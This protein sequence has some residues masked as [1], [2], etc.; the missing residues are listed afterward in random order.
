MDKTGRCLN[1][2]E[3]ISPNRLTKYEKARLLG[4]RTVQIDKNAPVLVDVDGETSSYEIA[5]KELMEKKIPLI[6]ER[7]LPNG[8]WELWS[9]DELII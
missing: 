3:R 2:D 9:I 1:K 7:I 4:T 8:D 6:V 5:I